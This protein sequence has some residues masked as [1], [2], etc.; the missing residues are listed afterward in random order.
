MT[1]LRERIEYV[2]ETYG[3][4]T[5]ASD[6]AEEMSILLETL[7]EFADKMINEVD[8]YDPVYHKGHDLHFHLSKDLG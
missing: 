8:C 4:G 7:E 2:K 3:E 1:T 6:F 5:V